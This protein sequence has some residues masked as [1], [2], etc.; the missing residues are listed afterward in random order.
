MHVHDEWIEPMLMIERLRQLRTDEGLQRRWLIVSFVVASLAIFIRCPS[1]ITHAQFYAEDGRTWY[2][3]AYNEG[4]L[5]SLTIPELGY[6]NTLQRLAAGLAVLVPFRW[7]P[8]TMALFG[9][10]WEAMPVPILL[11][12]RCRKWASLPMRI[13]FAAA[14]VVMPNVREIHVVCTNSQWHLAFVLGLLAFASPPEGLAGKIFD[15]VLFS[16]GAI[17]G[18]FGMLL[19]PLLGIFWFARR[20]RWTALIFW[21]LTAG[22]TVQALVLLHHYTERS[23]GYT[24]ATAA[25]FIRLLGGNAFIGALLGSR[26]FG[27][28][29]PFACSVCMLLAGLALCAYC[30]RRSG[31]EVLLF[32][33]Y[34]FA[35]FAAG[36]RSPGLAP[37]PR[38][39]W[40]GLLEIPAQRYSFFPGL[41][42]LF[43][44]LWCATSARNR[45]VHWTGLAL[46]LLLCIG[47]R[48]DLR[49]PRLP[50]VDFKQEV[51][52][53][54]A[55]APGQPVV[56]SI[57][58][59]GWHME[60]FK[61]PRTR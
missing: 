28:I 58:P 5:R 45:I 24:G 27:L 43:A 48:R 30:A 18:P 15:I 55:A 20:Q 14:Y 53:L 47:I 3:Q 61:K 9:L 54:K 25:L 8:L 37:D 17:S 56:L 57:S 32:F 39:L 23:E 44:V 50:Q 1:L 34:C 31:P 41:A 60:L 11:S 22:V 2:A 49:I 42:L 38:G 35:I 16:I 12:R 29:L 36:I 10:I 52:A 40:V 51:E 26:P 13:A 33:V 4:W 46:T 59:A 6:L 21:V 19:L 7:A